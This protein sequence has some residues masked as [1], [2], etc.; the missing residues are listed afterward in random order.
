MTPFSGWLAHFDY[1]AFRE[2]YAAAAAQAQCLTTYALVCL[3]ADLNAARKWD[4]Y[5]AHRWQHA[6]AEEW[7]GYNNGAVRPLEDS[8]LRGLHQRSLRAQGKYT[9]G[10]LGTY[11]HTLQEAM[12]EARRERMNK[13]LKE[14][15]T[16]RGETIEW[17]EIGKRYSGVFK[18]VIVPIEVA[19]ASV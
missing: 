9:D 16:A 15:L 8:V 2:Q 12:H 3:R 19:S 14:L 4:D 17:V 1:R 18:S 13:R 6:F 11:E 7:H 10:A 5:H